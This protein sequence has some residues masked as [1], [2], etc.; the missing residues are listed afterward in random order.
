LQQQTALYLGNILNKGINDAWNSIYSVL[1]SSEVYCLAVISQSHLDQFSTDYYYYPLSTS[2]LG[3]IVF[4]NQTHYNF[5]KE[6][7]AT[8]P[9]ASNTLAA[10]VQLSK[11]YE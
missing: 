1:G 7:N 11:H 6:N 3:I 8:S 5:N 9:L 4:S 2:Q 10:E